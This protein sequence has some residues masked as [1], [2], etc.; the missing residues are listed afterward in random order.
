MAFEPVV[1]NWLETFSNK[2]AGQVRDWLLE[3][4]KL[5][6][7]ERTVRRFVLKLRDKLYEHPYSSDESRHAIFFF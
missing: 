7:A 5:N 4:H 6:A 3:C 2:T 1:L